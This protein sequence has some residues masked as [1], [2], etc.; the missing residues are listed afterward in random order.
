MDGRAKVGFGPGHHPAVDHDQ[1]ERFEI[2]VDALLQM[3]PAGSRPKGSEFGR[4]CP[5][6]GT[7]SFVPGQADLAD[8][9]GQS[10]ITEKLGEKRVGPRSDK[11][12]D[13]GSQARKR[14]GCQLDQMTT[15]HFLPSCRAIEVGGAQQMKHT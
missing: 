13:G 11:A 5:A 2:G 3:P 1:I 4:Q 14:Q 12:G 9:C 15:V 7:G 8:A 6:S 10:G